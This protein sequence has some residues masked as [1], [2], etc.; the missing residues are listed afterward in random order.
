[1]QPSCQPAAKAERRQDV[2][3]VVVR[4]EDD[5][6]LELIKLEDEMDVDKMEV[7]F[8]RGPRRGSASLDVGGIERMGGILYKKYIR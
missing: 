2:K 6:S 3:W 1:M 8:E 5:F 4:S 7:G